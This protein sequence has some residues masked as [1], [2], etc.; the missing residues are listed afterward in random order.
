MKE[1]ENGRDVFD[2]KNE[3]VVVDRAER[4]Q[5]PTRHPFAFHHILATVI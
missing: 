1:N 4:V 5:S 3:L 2:L